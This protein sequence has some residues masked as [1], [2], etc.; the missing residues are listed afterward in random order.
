MPNLKL[1]SDSR[2]FITGKTG[3]GKTYLAQHLCKGVR[4][5]VVLD[6]K[7]SLGGWGLDPWAPETREA[8]LKGEPA[9]LRISADIH[10]D[11]DSLWDEG[12]QAVYAAGNCT[13]YIDE[14][15]AIVPPGQRPTQSLQAIWTR[16]REFNIGAWACSQR[17]TWCPLVVMSEAESYFM[18]R[19]TLLD[20]RRRMAAFMGEG[21][22]TRITDKHGFFYMDAES[23]SP[24][25]V[26]ELGG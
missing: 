21:V 11:P 5:L 15:Y 4:R 6:P 9:R 16:G 25:Y 20:D 3:S 12:M 22:L 17:P 26:K 23:E 24:L 2:I 13:L 10:D 8:L 14:I 19:L 18:F 7:G 1:R